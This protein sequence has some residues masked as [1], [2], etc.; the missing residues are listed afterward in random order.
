M[1]SRSCLTNLISFYFKVTCLVDVG[2]DVDVVYLAFRKALDSFFHRIFLEKLAAY[3]LTLFTGL[4]WLDVWT[5]R[6]M[7]NGLHTVG[8]WSLVGFLKNQD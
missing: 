5:Q 4:N 8:R 2:K 7:V 3:G 6:A 1:E